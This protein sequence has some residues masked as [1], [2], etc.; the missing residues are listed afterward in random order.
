MASLHARGVILWGGKEFK[1]F[2]R[3]EHGGVKHIEFSPKEG[4]SFNRF[5]LNFFKKGGIC[6][7]YFVR[8]LWG[9]REP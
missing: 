3:F 8:L 9:F 1:Q 7:K 2:Q 5:L 4:Y 6:K